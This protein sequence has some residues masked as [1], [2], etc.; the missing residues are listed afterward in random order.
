[1]KAIL[2]N[3]ILLINF[4]V[5]L[6]CSNDNQ[7]IKQEQQ[8]RQYI[9]EKNWPAVKDLVSNYMNSEEFIA[10]TAGFAV[11]PE[12]MKYP[13]LFDLSERLVKKCIQENSIDNLKRLGSE[14]ANRQKQNID[15]VYYYSQYAWVLWKKEEYLEALEN[16][17]KAIKY[18]IETGL[19][20]KG[21][22]LLRQGIIEY[23]NNNKEGWQKIKKALLTE[24][25]IEKQ[26]DDYRKALEKI[27]TIELGYDINSEQYIATYRKENRQPAP[28][29]TLVSFDNHEIDLSKQHGK[30]LFIN[31]FS[32]NCGSC[33][34]ELPRIKL[35][36]DQYFNNRDILFL[37]ILDKPNMRN[38]SIE[39]L[40]KLGYKNVPIF[41]V[42]SG[43]AWDYIEGEPTTW[44]IDRDGKFAYRHV[45]YKSGIEEIY[46]Q[47]LNK[48]L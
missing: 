46:K 39:L 23:Y 30:I 38:E 42:K 31:F 4:F 41:T 9:N 45:G 13:E 18:Q 29:L 2:K 10:H 8:F 43:S 20:T 7:S 6:Q 1:M 12:I 26:D 47:E 27:I 48:L 25:D 36:Y 34:H 37:F 28:E 24:S 40:K 11:L 15:F 33:R 14:N 44:I 21:Q 16:I 19:E 3:S 32:P 35:I 5:L 17:K 22:E